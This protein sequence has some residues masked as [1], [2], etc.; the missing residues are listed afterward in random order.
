MTSTQS[1]VPACRPFQ[2]LFSRGAPILFFLFLA[3]NMV[4]GQNANPDRNRTRHWVF[5]DSNWIEWTE[6]GPYQHPY[7]KAISTEEMA[8]F[9]DTGGHLQLYFDSRFVYDSSHNI[10][11]GGQ[12]STGNWTS[13]R[14]AVFIPYPGKDS[15]CYLFYTTY[16]S[17]NLN[18]R[19]RYALINWKTK[20]VV[21]KDQLLA[22]R[23]IEGIG[24]TIHHNNYFYWLVTA[25][26]T[27]DNLLFFLITDNGI[28]PCPFMQYN[29]NSY[30]NSSGQCGALFS[31]NG[32]S[33]TNHNFEDGKIQIA[34]FNAFNSALTDRI[35]RYDVEHGLLIGPEFSENEEY[36]YTA[37]SEAGTVAQL[38]QN[39]IKDWDTNI[40]AKQSQ[41]PFR[42]SFGLYRLSKNELVSGYYITE[43]WVDSVNLWIYKDTNCLFLMSNTNDS[44][45]PKNYNPNWLKTL[46]NIKYAPPNFPSSFFR[47][48]RSEVRYLTNCKSNQIEL[49]AITTGQENSLIWEVI[50]TDGSKT[51]Q[52]GSSIQVPIISSGQIK[53]KM[54]AKYSTGNDTI[55]KNIPVWEP[56]KKNILGADIPVCYDTFGINLSIP[57]QSFCSMWENGGSLTERHIDT[58]GIYSV[59][60]Y[61]SNYCLNF[62]TIKV[63]KSTSIDKPVAVFTLTD[64]IR[65]TNYLSSPAMRFVFKHNGNMDTTAIPYYSVKDTGNWTVW[66]YT[67]TGCYSD[68]TEIQIKSLRTHQLTAHL[69]NVYPNPVTETLN[70]S[71]SGP[72][73]YSLYNAQGQ[74]LEQGFGS[75]ISFSEFPEGLYVILISDENRMPLIKKIVKQ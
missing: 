32:H 50:N 22:T 59:K 70:F 63:F 31:V 75:T 35:I 58:F 19:L 16:E 24:A 28:I 34:H 39:R 2:I 60:F 66:A 26:N 8:V 61:D 20:T 15:F 68:T 73:K 6:N 33:I 57:S 7:S 53:V 52:S 38:A 43:R 44:F 51:T 47:E 48:Y 10:I 62:D 41:P 65:I 30:K 1:D 54:I 69:L 13:Y 40:I 46:H 25:S 42:Y 17:G 3:A 55:L 11:S 14:G 5:G 37:N 4:Q 49:E 12:I 45:V 18:N 71:P 9:T 27:S 23:V 56:V 74:L 29:A 67:T 64:S 21:K 72:H 36:L